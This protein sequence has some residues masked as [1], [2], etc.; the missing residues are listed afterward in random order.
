MGRV[1]EAEAGTRKFS[2]EDVGGG[3]LRSQEVTSSCDVLFRC[4]SSLDD[5]G[6]P[7]PDDPFV[8]TL[9]AVSGSLPGFLPQDLPGSSSSCLLH[10]VWASGSPELSQA[11][12]ED[13]SPQT[14]PAP[15][16]ETLGRS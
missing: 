12:T 15:P 3:G 4:P 2:R 10:P 11:G 16:E 7:V 14:P 13:T 8:P 5:F 1:A 6:C 9:T